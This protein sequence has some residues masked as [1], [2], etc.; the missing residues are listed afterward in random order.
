MV[1]ILVPILP[2]VAL[3]ALAGIGTYK[4]VRCIQ[5]KKATGHYHRHP[6][7]DGS[8]PCPKCKLEAAAAGGAE[9]PT[10]LE[11]TRDERGSDG[12]MARG[13]I[14]AP[15]YRI[16]PPDGSTI[17]GRRQSQAAYPPP[18]IKW[19]EDP[20][21]LAVE[22]PRRNFSSTGLHKRRLS[23]FYQARWPR[24]DMKDLEQALQPT[25]ANTFGDEQAMSSGLDATGIS[26]CIDHSE[27][28][29]AIRSA[30][31]E[32]LRDYESSLSSIDERE[33]EP[34][35]PPAD[36]E[37]EQNRHPTVD[38]PAEDEEDD[39][40][41][42]PPPRNIHTRSSSAPAKPLKS[43]LSPPHSPPGETRSSQKKRAR[44]QDDPS[45]SDLS[46]RRTSTAPAEYG[47]A[48]ALSWS[49]DPAEYSHG[50]EQAGSEEEVVDVDERLGS[51]VVEMQI[52]VDV[53]EDR[54]SDVDTLADGAEDAEAD[55]L[56]DAGG[57]NPHADSEDAD[58]EDTE[59]RVS[60]AV[61]DEDPKEKTAGSPSIEGSE[62]DASEVDAEERDLSPYL[63]GAEA[64]VQDLEAMEAQ[65]DA[66]KDVATEFASDRAT[67]ARSPSPSVSEGDEGEEA[68]F[69][70]PD[71]DLEDCEAIALP[72]EQ[73]AAESS[74]L[75]LWGVRAG[76]RAAAEDAEL[77]FIM[78]L[79]SI[80]EIEEPDP[81]AESPRHVP[82]LARRRSDLNAPDRVDPAAPTTVRR[83]SSSLTNLPHPA[84]P[85]LK[86]RP[87]AAKT[88]PAHPALTACSVRAAE[89]SP[90]LNTV[91]AHPGAAYFS[92]RATADYGRTG[93]KTA[94]TVVAGPS[95]YQIL[96]EE[97]PPPGEGDSDSDTTLLEE[98]G[99]SDDEESAHSLTASA[100]LSTS[101]MGR[102]KTKLA[103]W[104]WACAHADGVA[105]ARSRDI[106]LM[107]VDADARRERSE[108]PPGPP[109]T[110]KHS[111]ASS[112]RHSGPQTPVREQRPGDHEEGVEEGEE[113]RQVDD[114]EGADADG[115]DDQPMELR[116]AS[117]PATT[118]Y[119]AVPS[120]TPP[121]PPPPPPHHL[122][123][124][125]PSPP[126][127]SLAPSPTSRPTRRGSTHTATRWT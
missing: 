64:R 110:E 104:S 92:R 40:R 111:A 47:G 116:S 87:L 18:N 123:P 7:L 125:P 20:Q 96:W 74:D 17:G 85:Q 105:G 112:T 97:S 34:D 22:G 21:R 114:D 72:L 62:V 54:E 56:E 46:L 9:S 106:P 1:L 5:R 86:P 16:L 26:E 109:N 68:A 6:H 124:A 37:A 28:M 14:D 69:L 84:N 91:Y 118:E 55:M 103:A 25:P 31:D 36:R 77:D 19:A 59:A 50:I 2:C 100:D 119:L 51:I 70:T 93:M 45:R 13:A 58:I 41:S 10:L 90:R 99:V 88:T 23:D 127:P 73:P 117:L 81:P 24:D 49:G 44:F 80:G 4:G 48:S 113:A 65:S 98:P 107:R 39:E 82:V 66:D 29:P 61:V 108:D 53:V 67:Q 122:P 38:R 32:H 12:M 89:S 121:P 79:I 78:P 8:A 95:T 94:Q 15:V 57:G 43:A 52:D 71:R 60:G 35:P 63:E 30:L 75:H 3:I 101:P 115:E 120:S 83:R 76:E 126:G 11:E 33:P 42:S 102:A 27:R